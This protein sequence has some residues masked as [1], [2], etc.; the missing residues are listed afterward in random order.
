MRWHNVAPLAVAVAIGLTTTS[1][2]A[3]GPGG[4]GGFG[5]PGG[6]QRGAS[7]PEELI[8]R[9][10]K[11]DA[12]QD[13]KLTK[14]EVTD[15]RLLHLFVA[16]DADKD[17]VLTTEEMQTFFASQANANGGQR[18]QGGGPGGQGM[19]PGG[20][21]G[22]GMGPGGMMGPP[23]I[24]EVMPDF[25]QQMLNLTPQQRAAVASLQQKVN[26]ELAAIL[27]D[28]QEAQIAQMM[29][30]GPGGQRGQRGGR[31]QR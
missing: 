28:E 21:G 24:G 7:S 31:G 20:P 13:G 5:G 4:R 9:M 10:M 27:T 29:Q 8:A 30:G 15:R 26:A 2:W 22:P 25:V 14:E 18:G 23:R 17:D 3:Q 16:A 11:L 1:L 19:G 6:N 12:D